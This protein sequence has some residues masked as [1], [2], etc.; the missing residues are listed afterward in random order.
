MDTPKKN[1]MD[2]AGKNIV[3]SGLF[4]QKEKGKRIYVAGAYTK[5]DV[6]INVRKALLVAD[7]LIE[8]GYTPYVPHLSHFWHFLSPKTY[9]FWLKYDL[10][11]LAYWAEGV[12]RLDNESKG[13]DHEVALALSLDIPVYY[14]IESLLA[15]KEE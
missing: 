14:G 12:L 4:Y 2:L 3:A 15:V 6:I 9:G 7:H 13:A 11:F 1:R 8:L 10:S 5:G